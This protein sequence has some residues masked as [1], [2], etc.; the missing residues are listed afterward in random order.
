MRTLTGE[1]AWCYEENGSLRVCAD[2]ALWLTV[3]REQCCD[4]IAAF[5]LA[6]AHPNAE[7]A[8]ARTVQLDEA[9]VTVGNG[10]IIITTTAARQTR[11]G[12][13]V[14]YPQSPE[15]MAGWV[16]A[17]HRAIAAR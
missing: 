16:A 15:S 1:N 14:A 12:Q 3:D 6:A 8:S 2:H 11:S 5:W 7:T 17:A 4:L 13:R 9:D 10:A